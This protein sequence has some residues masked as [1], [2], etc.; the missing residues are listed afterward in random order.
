MCTSKLDGNQ[1]CPQGV[2]RHLFFCYYAASD[3]I[4]NTNKILQVVVDL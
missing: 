2:S 4:N 3:A 1:C